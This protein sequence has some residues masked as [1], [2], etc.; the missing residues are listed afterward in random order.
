MTS[1]TEHSASRGR[2]LVIAPSSAIRDVLTKHANHRPLVALLT[3]HKTGLVELEPV[4]QSL[5]DRGCEY[6]VCFGTGSE[7]LHDRIDDLVAERAAM[8]PDLKVVTTW[9]EDETLTEV[10]EFF[11]HVA[12]AKEGSL[13]VAALD[14]GQ[15]EMARVLTSQ[16]G[17]N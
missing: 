16:V 3:P 9:H 15:T 11:V 8:V 5:L 4:I 1:G 13:L 7:A 10:A 2:L 14:E 17:V 12:A 6:F